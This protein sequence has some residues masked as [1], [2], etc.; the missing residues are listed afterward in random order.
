[1][2]TF[3]LTISVLFSFFI[4]AQTSNI[5]FEN[6]II[7]AKLV[8]TVSYPDTCGKIDS[9]KN[10][11]VLEFDVLRQK[12]KKIFGKKI[13]AATICDDFPG[14]GL[15]DGKEVDLKLYETKYYQW[16]I[17][18]LNEDLLAK[19]VNR[20]KY[21]VKSISRKITVYCATAKK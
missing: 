20:K 3:I 8:K 1:M 4:K 21:W 6:R 15:F 13:H 5:A 16:D 7:K 18:I 9:K 11:I 19:N 17:S 2:R 12:D 10:A 14:E